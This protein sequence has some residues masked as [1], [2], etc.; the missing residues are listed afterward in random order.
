MSQ[1]KSLIYIELMRLHVRLRAKPHL[2]YI[3]GAHV[4]AASAGD[5]YAYE[6][7]KYS[8]SIFTYCILSAFKDNSADANADGKLTI[9]E[10][11]SYVIPKV[12]ELSDGQ[13]KPTIRQE[14][15]SYDFSVWVR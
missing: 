2:W 8:N 12:Y 9:A 15:L 7:N 3:T 11:K 14:N 10:L 4:M 6:Y 5:K 1:R 13:Q